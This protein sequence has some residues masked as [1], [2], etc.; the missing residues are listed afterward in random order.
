V[1][2]AL[3]VIIGVVYLEYRAKNFLV[4][5]DRDTS[6]PVRSDQPKTSEKYLP[7][8]YTWRLILLSFLLMAGLAGAAS[9][10]EIKQDA[11]ALASPAALTSLAGPLDATNAATRFYAVD[12]LG[13]IGGSATIAPLA[14]LCMIQMCAC[15][16]RQPGLWAVVLIW[17]RLPL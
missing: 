8:N 7:R 1:S 16:S 2:L 4:E 14:K 11:K 6:D 12:S 17:Q 5:A 3:A 10:S 13:K 15:A 9:E